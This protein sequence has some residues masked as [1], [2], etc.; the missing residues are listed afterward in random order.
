MSLQV[1]CPSCGAEHDLLA[2]LNAE[3]ARG[4][5]GELLLAVLPHARPL[6]RYVALFKPA[7]RRLSQERTAKLLLPLLADMKAA[8][9]THKGRPWQA[10]SAVWLHALEVVAQQADKLT[11]PLTNHAYLYS[12]I[13]SSA[14]KVEAVAER[15]AEADKLHTARSRAGVSVGGDTLVPLAAA[16]APHVVSKPIDPAT[17]QPSPY[18][19]KEKAAAAARLAARK[20]AQ[21]APQEPRHDA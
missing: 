1:A 13:A 14:D 20:E 17:Y 5:L 9:I 16:A 8:V 6:L 18:A 10:P 11:L 19:R 12:V 2:V 15:Q 21:Q 4:P 7:S 3:A